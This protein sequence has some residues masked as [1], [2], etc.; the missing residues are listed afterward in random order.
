MT[1][2]LGCASRCSISGHGLTLA[3]AGISAFVSVTILDSY[4][5]SLPTSCHSAAILFSHSQNRSFGSQAF[6]CV[7]TNTAVL[8]HFVTRSG[9][10]GIA[11]HG[12]FSKFNPCYD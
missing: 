6:T 3:T 5:N 4:D 10:Y 2:G 8:A 1:S 12:L 11:V 7:E 9:Q